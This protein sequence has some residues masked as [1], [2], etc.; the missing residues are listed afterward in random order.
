MGTKP[1]GVSA[2]Q[3]QE[4]LWRVRTAREA[5]GWGRALPWKLEAEGVPRGGRDGEY[6]VKCQIKEGVRVGRAGGRWK[7]IL[8][9]RIC[10]LP[11]LGGPRSESVS[12][13]K[14]SDL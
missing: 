9:F 12:A 2:F 3:V 10:L 13:V 1:G 14:E 5:G 4:P 8:P 11:G 6:N 7:H